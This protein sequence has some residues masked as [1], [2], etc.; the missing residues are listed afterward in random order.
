M[1]AESVGEAELQK[2]KNHL[3]G[4]LMIGLE[5]SDE[6]ASFYGNQEIFRQKIITPKELAKR[7]EAVTASE[8]W[9][10]AKD[11]IKNQHLNLALIGPFKDRKPF[12]KILKI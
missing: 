12:E 3:S 8:I 1:A 4:Q 2:S 7:I 11:L 5:G 10:V 9:K 6:L